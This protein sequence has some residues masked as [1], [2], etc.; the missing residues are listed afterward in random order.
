MDRVRDEGEQGVAL[1]TR[2]RDLQLRVVS[3]AEELDGLRASWSALLEES[4]ATVFQ[5]FEWLRAWW[6]HFGQPDRHRKLHVLVLESQGQAQA[7]A[8][9]FV[10]TVSIG[11]GVR[12]RRLHFLG[13][14]MTD[15][16]D[17]V[18]RKG[19]ESDACE[20][21]AA[22]AALHDG[23]DLVALQ[24]IPDSSPCRTP[25]YDALNRHGFAGQS[26]V[27]EQCPR[28][29]LEKSWK[30]TCFKLDVGR[31]SSHRIANRIKKI[32]ESFEVELEVCRDAA[33]LDADIDEFMTQHQALWTARGKAGVYADPA[34]A[35]FQ[36]EIARGF[37]GRGWLYL[38]FLKVDGKRL[39]SFCGI[40]YR[41]VLANYL[42][43]SVAEGEVSKH[44]PGLILQYLSIENAMD[45]GVRVFDFLRGT[46]KYKYD[47]KG[48]DAPNWTLLLYRGG[49]RTARL[50]NRVALLEESLVRRAGQER[51]AF[52]HARSEHGLWSEGMAQWLRA[53]AVQTVQDGLK[54]LRQPEKSLT[55][56]G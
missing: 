27:N 49:A 39:C 41:D 44:S 35:A 11:P 52:E 8:P 30:D 50:K 55:A 9:W 19:L 10:E 37:F 1:D 31:K 24:D 15:Y 18:V 38:A 42:G 26:F 23:F 13:H 17:L 25:L 43:G 33:R 54:K 47:A 2:A 29:T 28:L 51:I 34:A 56:A 7:I 20:R 48:V 14:G 16:L 46:E 32:R 12:V 45:E 40:K 53:R 5:S 21:F 22:H 6:K 4:G 36:R 3:S